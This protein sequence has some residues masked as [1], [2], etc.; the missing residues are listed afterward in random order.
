MIVENQNGNDK[1]SKNR[2]R[3]KKYD[4]LEKKLINREIK[5]VRKFSKGHSKFCKPKFQKPFAI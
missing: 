2:G 1:K 3:T 4:A 5:K